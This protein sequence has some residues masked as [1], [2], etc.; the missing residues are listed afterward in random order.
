MLEMQSKEGR[1]KSWAWYDCPLSAW[2]ISKIR[3]R[4]S[5]R[6][7]HI[8]THLMHAPALAAACFFVLTLV[9]V[10][11]KE[12]KFSAFY[13]I[14]VFSARKSDITLVKQSSPILRRGDEWKR[15]EGKIQ[16]SLPKS[17]FRSEIGHNTYGKEEG[18]L[19]RRNHL[20]LLHIAW[21]LQ[22]RNRHCRPRDRPFQGK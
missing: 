4:Q 22:K 2:K 6:L 7:F 19:Q 21:K 12:Q 17:L 9:I 14:Q 11:E 1:Q 3:A 15:S 18:P 5:H 20:T 8:Q 10:S 16:K 13:R